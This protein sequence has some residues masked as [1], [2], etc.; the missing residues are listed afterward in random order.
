M[1]M[2]PGDSSL[3]SVCVHVCVFLI[4][5]QL[6]WPAAHFTKALAAPQVVDPDR[7]TNR[8]DEHTHALSLIHMHTQMN[9]CVGTL[10]TEMRSPTRAG[11]G[12]KGEF[13]GLFL[14]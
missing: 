3:S 1:Q 6:C 11:E 9:T 4:A 14:A 12:G 7:N 8:G 5:S 10:R 13:C 2:L